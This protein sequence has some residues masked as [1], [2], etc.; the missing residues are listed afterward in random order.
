[1]SEV[2]TPPPA[3]RS[4]ETLR[5]DEEML[6]R[7]VA[8]A[9]GCEKE[10]MGWLD[11]GL[12]LEQ[13]RAEIEQVQVKRA[14]AQKP[15]GHI[16]LSAKE[17]RAYNAASAIRAIVEQSWGPGS[18]LEREVSDEIA[19]RLGKDGG[20]NRFFLPLNIRASVTGQVAGTSSLG[21]AAVPT[22]Q[23]PVI[24]IL[25]NKV[26][27]ARAGASVMSGLTGNI[28]FPRQITANTATAVGE[29]PTAASSLTSLTMDTVTMSPKTI[30]A[31]TAFSRQLAVQMSP[32]AQAFITN[33][34]LNVVAI[35]LDYLAINGSG[36]G[37]EPR[38]VRNTSGIGNRTLGS[39]GAALTWAELVGFETDVATG[40]ADYGRL[41]FVCNAVTRGKLK[42]TLKST[43]AG[44]TYL[45]EGGNDP[46]TINGYNA[47]VS[48][49]LPSNL[50]Q[51]TSTTICSSIVFG[52]WA[53]LLIGEWGGAI[54]ILVDPFTSAKQNMVELHAYAMMDCAV[55]HAASFSKSDAVLT[56]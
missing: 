45:W 52:N 10:G 27:A 15:A 2:V 40:N 51:G 42:T 14:A 50:T 34:I 29:N 36:S 4:A 41:G 21:G 49:Q 53:E 23:G 16:D 28:S 32:D 26:I 7:Q 19:K 39:A 35:K 48:N 5:S 3:V 8:V 24:E 38:G 44:A 47:F 17:E 33:D 31:H 9:F 25:R 54:E 18:G 22:L 12:S 43:T 13:V 30:D 11:R 1:M 6:I 20:P 55:R 56:T 37:A 46:G